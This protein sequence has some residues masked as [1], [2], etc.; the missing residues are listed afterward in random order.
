MGYVKDMMLRRQEELVG[1]IYEDAYSV[2]VAEMEQIQK[3]AILPDYVILGNG[4]RCYIGAWCYP[5][6]DVCECQ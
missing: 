5:V 3:D 2:Y 6:N 4:K 1:E